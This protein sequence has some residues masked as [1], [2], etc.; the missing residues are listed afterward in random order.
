[1]HKDIVASCPYG[2][3]ALGTSPQCEVQGMYV[4]NKLITL[5]GHP[6]FGG[7]IMLELLKARSDLGI[8]VDDETYESALQRAKNNHDGVLVAKVVLRFF[9]SG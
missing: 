6:E 4:P 1:M 8:L 9:L 7:Y 3:E 2:V 5:Q